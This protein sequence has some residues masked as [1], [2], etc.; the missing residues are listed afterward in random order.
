M[1]RPASVLT[2]LNPDS[3]IFKRIMAIASAA[4]LLLTPA[5]AWAA[6][7]HHTD[8]A[9]Q[10]VHAGSQVTLFKDLSGYDNYG[11]ADA[12]ADILYSGEDDTWF[13]N[14]AQAGVDPDAV[15]SAQVR[16]NLVLDDHYE[17]AASEYNGSIAVN[18]GNVFS[19]SFVSLGIQHGAPFGNQFNN[20]QQVSQSVSVLSPS[21]TWPLHIANTTSGSPG[22]DWIAIDWI[23]FVLTVTPDGDGDGV[24]DANDDCPTRPGEAAYAGCPVTRYPVNFMTFIPSNYI[25]ASILWRQFPI[26]IPSGFL[27]GTACTQPGT[28]VSRILIG[29]G[30]DRGYSFAAASAPTKPYRT[31]QKVTIVVVDKGTTKEFK[32]EAPANANGISESYVK[33]RPGSGGALNHGTSGRID[34]SD[35][36]NDGVLGDCFLKHASHLGS[37]ADMITPTVDQVSATR[38]RVTLKGSAKNGLIPLSPAI[39]WNLTLDLEVGMPAPRVFINGSRDQFPAYEIYVNSQRVYEFAPGSLGAAQIPVLRFGALDLAGLF[40]AAYAPI[41]PVQRP[42]E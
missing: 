7:T 38:G 2:R 6:S 22:G 20:W 34:P 41:S 8:P 42:L 4:T 19:G 28:D 17:R 40:P 37:T 24:L 18:G 13:F 14:L 32:A 21:A 23:E 11:T 9:A 31:L 12:A 16:M 26:P 36:D 29:A 33:Q 30:D 3:R 15:V 10:V 5:M 35:N 25:D 1:K 39:D 27:P